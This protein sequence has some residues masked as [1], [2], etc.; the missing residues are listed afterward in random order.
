MAKD[1]LQ[2]W[3]TSLEGEAY[4]AGLAASIRIQ[5]VQQASRLQQ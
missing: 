4:G 1:L 5:L 3:L 2:G